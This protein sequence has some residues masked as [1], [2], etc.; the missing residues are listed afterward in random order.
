[1]HVRWLSLVLL[2]VSLF[3][4]SG[5]ASSRY[6]RYGQTGSYSGVYGDRGRDV[7][8]QRNSSYGW[9]RQQQR[10]RQEW[11]RRQRRQE[12]IERSRDREWRNERRRY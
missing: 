2:A 1:M 4:L 5:C 11:R 12:R 8:I 7:Y 10:A 3:A 6:G 9:E